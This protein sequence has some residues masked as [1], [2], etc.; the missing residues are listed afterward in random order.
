[1]PPVATRFLR[2][3]LSFEP[4]RL[5]DDLR[6]CSAAQ[7]TRH[8]NQQ[9]YTGAWTGIALRSPSGA[10]DDLLSIPGAERYRDTPLLAECRYFSAVLAALACDTEAVRLLRLAP[11]AVIR[12]HRDRGACYADG[13]F[14]LHVPITTNSQ[15]RFVVD[16]ESLRM[17]PGECWY[18]D[19]TLPHSVRNDGATDRVHLIIDGC[20]NAGS[21]RLF[22]SAGYDFAAE[23]RERRMDPQTRRLVIDEL[24]RRGGDIELQ[25]ARQLEQGADAP[26]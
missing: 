21:D 13:C 25:L 17:Q 15:T 11:G 7:W 3:P 23:A 9:D 14:R 20:R 1:M 5:V 26:P 24:R 16:G 18:A 19:F 22:E 4:A 6:R 2:L 10:P 8:A 12:E